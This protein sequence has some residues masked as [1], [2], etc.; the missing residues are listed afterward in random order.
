MRTT[1]PIILVI[2][3]LISPFTQSSEL[4]YQ[5]VNP[6]FGGNALNGNFLMSVANSQNTYT[7]PDRRESSYERPSDIDR[8]TSSLQS[9]LLSQLLT[10]LGE[11]N[12]GSL[13]TDDF[14]ID[15]IDESGNLTIIIEDLFTNERTEIEVNGSFNQ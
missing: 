10:D 8:F 2:N 14:S 9:R 7:D 12:T 5:A 1:I 13:I 11:D 15:I 3:L 4:I 6:N